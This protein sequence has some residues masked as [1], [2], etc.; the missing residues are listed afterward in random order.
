MLHAWYHLKEL[1]KLCMSN[2]F[3]MHTRTSTTFKR[4][5]SESCVLAVK[6]QQVVGFLDSQV[7]V[8]LLAHE[9]RSLTLCEALASSFLL[10]ACVLPA[11]CLPCLCVTRKRLTL[12]FSP[13]NLLLLT[14]CVCLVAREQHANQQPAVC[15]RSPLR[16]CLTGM[17]VFTYPGIAQLW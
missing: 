11:A 6:S 16:A 1:E 5:F 17:C 2:F 7:L 15:L 10:A 9:E 3:L 12:T 4:H 8:C 13:Y 14:C